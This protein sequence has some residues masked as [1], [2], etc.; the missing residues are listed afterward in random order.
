MARGVMQQK[1]CIAAKAAW[2]RTGHA[3]ASSQPRNTLAASVLAGL[4]DVAGHFLLDGVTGALP[5]PVAE[6]GTRWPV[7][8]DGGARSPLATAHPRASKSSLAWPMASSDLW[9]S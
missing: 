6:A 9:H 1:C 8:H 4:P 5:E 2:G 3:V 7:R